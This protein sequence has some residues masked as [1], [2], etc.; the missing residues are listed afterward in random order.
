[1]DLSIKMGASNILNNKVIQVYGGPFI[2]RMA[3]LSLSFDFKDKH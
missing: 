1:M 3:Y 2:G